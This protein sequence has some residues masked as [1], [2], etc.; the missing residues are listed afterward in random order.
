MKNALLIG[1]GNTRGEKII[2]G[3]QDAGYKVTN[4]GQTES[5]LEKVNNIKVTWK[6][7]DITSLHKIL[8]NLFNACIFG[9]VLRGATM[10]P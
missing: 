8:H 10:I 4:I 9:C 5:K 3:C 1:C 7:L 2:L 6:E